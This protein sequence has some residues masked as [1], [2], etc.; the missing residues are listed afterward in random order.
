MI[1]NLYVIFDRVAEESTPIFTAKNDGIAVRMTEDMLR[2]RGMFVSDDFMLFQVGSY[3]SEKMILRSCE[4]RQISDNGGN[5]NEK[6]EK[7]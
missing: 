6:S 7:K 4:V 5:K 3:D 1:N 2:G